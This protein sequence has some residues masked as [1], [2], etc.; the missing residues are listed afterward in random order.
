MRKHRV[1]DPKWMA[2]E[3]DHTTG[4]TVS[5]SFKN[6]YPCGCTTLDLFILGH[7]WHL[8]ARVGTCYPVETTDSWLTGTSLSWITT[9]NWEQM[10]KTFG[11]SWAACRDISRDFPFHLHYKRSATSCDGRWYTFRL[12]TDPDGSEFTL[13]NISSL[14]STK[15]LRKK[16][17][18]RELAHSK[19][20]SRL[21]SNYLH[22]WTCKNTNQW[23]GKC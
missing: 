23:V 17:Q 18:E 3:T 10:K 1:A 14:L 21:K 2:G 7:F 6:L 11:K 20:N 4:G 8:Q 12:W 9:H 15:R 5:T 22:N 19:V 13:Q 16:N